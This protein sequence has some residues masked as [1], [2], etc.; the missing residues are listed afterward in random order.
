MIHSIGTH[1]EGRDVPGGGVTVY[2]ASLVLEAKGTT[3]KEAMFNLLL[4]LAEQGLS[5]DV[6]S[7][8][9]TSTEPPGSTG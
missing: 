2:T 8:D 1:Y 9:F 4:S 7:Y 6:G 3:R 5:G